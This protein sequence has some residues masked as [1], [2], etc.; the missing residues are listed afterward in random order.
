LRDFNP[1]LSSDRLFVQTHCLMHS[2][3]A[4]HF[5]SF[6]CLELCFHMVPLSFSRTASMMRPLHCCWFLCRIIGL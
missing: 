6:A 2:P 4:S 1:A 3:L 5:G